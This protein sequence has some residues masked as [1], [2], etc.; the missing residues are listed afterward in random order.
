MQKPDS[1]GEKEGSM[2][3]ELFMTAAI[4]AFALTPSIGMGMA[5]ANG[6]NIHVAG[7]HEGVVHGG[8]MRRDGIHHRGFFGARGFPGNGLGYGG[9]IGY[10]DP[11]IAAEA[12][13]VSYVPQPAPAVPAADRPPCHEMTTAGVVIDRGSSCSRGAP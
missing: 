9:F 3:R 4:V 6:A 1:E 8:D 11:E 12:P 5:K 13:P 7:V 2:T 10:V